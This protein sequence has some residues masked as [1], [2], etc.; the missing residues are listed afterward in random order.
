VNLPL[1]QQGATVRF[2][3]K[4]V[5]GASRDRIQGVL[6]TQL[7]VQVAA[8][9]EGGKANERLCE[10]LAAA[11][12]VP[13]RAVEVMAGHGSPRKTVAVSGLGADVVLAR[14]AAAIAG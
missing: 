2:Q 8:P 12:A 5:P 9:P 6:G 4:V 10:L 7:K 14:L 3:V 1:Q 11:L 13:P